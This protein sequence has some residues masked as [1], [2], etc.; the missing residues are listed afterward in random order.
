MKRKEFMKRLGAL[1]L[2]AA[3]IASEPVMRVG[4]APKEDSGEKNLV[5]TTELLEVDQS[6]ASGGI[7]PTVFKD[8]YQNPDGT[9]R[10]SRATLPAEFDLRTDGKSTTVK[11]QNPWGTC[12][13]FGALSSLESS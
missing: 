1:G 5:K 4:A 11:N 8:A 6:N 3:L 10:W 13:A 9:Q 7:T 2:A 12:W